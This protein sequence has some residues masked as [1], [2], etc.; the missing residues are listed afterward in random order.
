[1][2]GFIFFTRIIFLSVL[3]HKYSYM[4]SQK[5]LIHLLFW[6]S[7]SYVGIFHIPAYMSD[8][9]TLSFTGS[10]VL[11]LQLLILVVHTIHPIN[12]PS[13]IG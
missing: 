11:L 9:I 2:I 7:T 8:G 4:K 6:A 5:L 3:F 10:T 13:K 1:M 12:P